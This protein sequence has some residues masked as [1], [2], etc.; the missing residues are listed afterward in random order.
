MQ[1]ARPRILVAYASRLGSTA[2]VARFVGTVLSESG[3]EVTVRALADVDDLTAYESVVVGS[4][5]RYDRW[6]PDAV[7]FVRENHEALRDVPVAM[8]FTCLTLAKPTPDALRKAAGYADRLRALA[9]DLQPV[10][11]GGFAGVLA[12][13]RTPWPM[14]WVL[15]LLSV[16]TGVPEGDHRDWEAIRDWTTR[17]VH[18]GERSSPTG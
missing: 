8:F 10:A 12:F 13:A 9:P 1:N 4:A 16:I 11:I 5:I 18:A 2:E 6:L 17:I 14:R 3:A 7:A 15:R